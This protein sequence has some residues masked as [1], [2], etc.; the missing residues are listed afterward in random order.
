[1]RLCI[2]FP[3]LGEMKDLKTAAQMHNARAELPFPAVQVGSHSQVLK[4][5]KLYVSILPLQL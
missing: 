3:I 5:Q 1:M 2:F 4:T